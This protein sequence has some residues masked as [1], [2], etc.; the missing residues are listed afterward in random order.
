[1]LHISY[2]LQSVQQGKSIVPYGGKSV[3]T[4]DMRHLCVCLHI[5]ACGCASHAD[6]MKISEQLKQMYL[7]NT[8]RVTCV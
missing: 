1:M 5:A 7:Q 8:G 2:N 6:G 3:Y 4:C